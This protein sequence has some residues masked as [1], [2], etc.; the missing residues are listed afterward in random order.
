[1]TEYTHLTNQQNKKE[2]QHNLFEH[3]SYLADTPGFESVLEAICRK[4]LNAYFEKDILHIDFGDNLILSGEPAGDLE[5]YKH[6]PQS[7]QKCI[8]KHEYLYFPEKGWSV[9]LGDHVYLKLNIWTM[10]NPICLAI[11]MRKMF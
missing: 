3:F 2:F 9:F 10:T 4:T 8:S 6:W 5:K 1:M 7:F 11:L